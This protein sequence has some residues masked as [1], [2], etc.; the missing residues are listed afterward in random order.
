MQF[1][2]QRLHAVHGFNNVGARLAED[3]HQNR[4]LAVRHA[5]VAN[6]LHRILHVSHIL[7][8]HYARAVSCDDDVFVIICLEELIVGGDLPGIHRVGQLAL[9]LV[10]ICGAQS[11]AHLLH[12]YA[13]LAQ[14][15]W[16]HLRA[17]R[18]LCA[19]AYKDLANPLHL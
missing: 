7:Q 8:P 14:Q 17:H 19:T 10:R 11:R 1:G 5:G 3:D 4:R 13:Q 9:G 15:S 16:I 18:W 6:V 12:P 2:N